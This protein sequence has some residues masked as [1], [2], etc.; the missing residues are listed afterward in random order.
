[1]IPLESQESS[2]PI[3]TRAV[4]AGLSGDFIDN[5]QLP[6]CQKALLTAIGAFPEWVARF[7]ISRF[8]AISGLPPQ[9]MDTFSL[10]DLLRSRLADYSGLPGPFPAITLGAA[11]GGATTYLS[12]ALGGPFLP[13]TFVVT[14]KGGSLSGDV[15]EYLHRSLDCA[16]KCRA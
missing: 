13:Q 15:N 9:V 3:V 5:Y 14:L 4:A 16:R 11:L 6:G 8:Q 12:L 2:S 1:M 10:D 7:A